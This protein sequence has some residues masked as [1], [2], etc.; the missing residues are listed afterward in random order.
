MR[1]SKNYKNSNGRLVNTKEYAIAW[2]VINKPYSARDLYKKCQ[3]SEAPS[4]KFIT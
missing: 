3:D 4:Y 1:K 2:G